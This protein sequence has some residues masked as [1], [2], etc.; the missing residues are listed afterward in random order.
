[1]G[2]EPISDHKVFN[3][4]AHPRIGNILNNYRIDLNARESTWPN[5]MIAVSSNNQNIGVILD[6]IRHLLI[7]FICGQ[8]YMYTVYIKQGQKASCFPVP[9]KRTIP[10]VRGGREPP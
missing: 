5:P 1:M 8:A 3:Y 2:L 10:R 9:D 6:F 4:C 7:G